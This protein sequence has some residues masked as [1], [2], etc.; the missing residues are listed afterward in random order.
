MQMEPN[1]LAFVTEKAPNGGYALKQIRIVDGHAH[2]DIIAYRSSLPE[3]NML[4]H[5]IE[6]GT[7]HELA[8][9]AAPPQ[10]MLIPAQPQPQ[11]QQSQPQPPAPAPAQEPLPHYEEAEMARRFAHSEMPEPDQ[12][13]VNSI[14]ARMGM[15]GRAANGI[16]AF[17]F[18][19]AVSLSFGLR[20][21]VA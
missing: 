16:V 4:R 1:G 12:G 20:G 11:P 21:M 7:F 13:L 15:N 2:M 17:A 3:L 10:P 5:S 19:A 8:W 14:K 18:C 9:F 6:E